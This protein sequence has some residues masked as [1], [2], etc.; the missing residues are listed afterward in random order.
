MSPPWT[1]LVRFLAEEDGQIHLGQVDA[2]KWPDVGLG[3]FKGEKIE[4]KLVTGTIYDGVVT[5]KIMHISKV[6]ATISEYLLLE[7]MLI[8]LSNSYY[9]QSQRKRCQSS[10]AW[11]STTMK[12]PKKRRRPLQRF[13]FCSSGRELL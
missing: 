6:H 3:T 8:Q 5:D 1:H 4:A 7:S 12:L 11:A 13:Q 9:R 2:K 10:A